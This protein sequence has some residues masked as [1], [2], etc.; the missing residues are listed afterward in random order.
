MWDSKR[1]YVQCS[2][3]GLPREC[4]YAVHPV[5]LCCTNPGENKKTE[6]VIHCLNMPFG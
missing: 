2:C 6:R 5:A 4:G 3:F 1:Q